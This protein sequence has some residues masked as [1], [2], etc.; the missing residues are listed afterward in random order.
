MYYIVSP[1]LVP[2]VINRY[3]AMATSLF[4]VVILY[5]IYCTCNAVP[6]DG[7]Y[8]III[9]KVDRFRELIGA[10]DTE[11]FNIVLLGGT[12][13]WLRRVLSLPIM[14]LDNCCGVCRHAG[15][16]VLSA[17]VLYLTHGGSCLGCLW[18]EASYAPDLCKSLHQGPNRV[19]YTRVHVV[20]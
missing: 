3:V 5:C 13:T 17:S 10:P 4:A 19:H 18:Q 6:Q 8:G 20:S 12:V 16:H 2:I 7:L 15:I 11:K 14:L 9:N 1:A